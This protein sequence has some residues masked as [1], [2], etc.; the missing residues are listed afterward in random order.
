MDCMDWS[1][2][3]HA[4]S[5]A[6]IGLVIGRLLWG[7]VV[8]AAIHRVA[9]LEGS[10]PPRHLPGWPGLAWLSMLASAAGNVAFDTHLAAVIAAPLCALLIAG[11]HELPVRWRIARATRLERARLRRELRDNEGRRP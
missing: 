11:Y 2:A 8:Y 4:G 1:V 9:Q 6:A 10:S 5:G 7:P 3:F